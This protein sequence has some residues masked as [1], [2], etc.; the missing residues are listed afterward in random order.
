MNCILSE[1][2]V[3]SLG[4][5]HIEIYSSMCPIVNVISVF[6]CEKMKIRH[7]NTIQTLALSLFYIT[8][9]HCQVWKKNTVLHYKMQNKKE[10]LKS[11]CFFKNFIFQGILHIWL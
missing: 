6:K 9:V 4:V 10:N 11:K 7:K 3:I 5:N 2:N 1:F 8:D